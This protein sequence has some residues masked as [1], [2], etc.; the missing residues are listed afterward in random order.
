MYSRD[1]FNDSVAHI[2]VPKLTFEYGIVMDWLSKPPVPED[3]KNK[4]KEQLPEFTQ[5][6]KE[7]GEPLLKMT[8]C[9][10]G[11]KFNRHELT[12]ACVLNPDVC[13]MSQPLIINAASYIE[14]KDNTGFVYDVYLQL[15]RLYIEEHFHDLL[16][17]S[18]LANSFGLT[19]GFLF[20]CSVTHAVFQ[21]TGRVAELNQ[22]TAG[23]A[24]NSE[25]KKAWEVVKQDDGYKLFIQELK[26]HR[27]ASAILF[28]EER[29]K[30]YVPHIF[31]E[32]A[33]DLDE[34]SGA[35]VPHSLITRFRNELMPE[36]AEYWKN[37][38]T[39]LVQATVAF[40]KKGFPQQELSVA[41]ALDPNTRPMSFP[42]LTNARR[43]FHLNDGLEKR[44]RH[45]FCS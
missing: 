4:L 13:S 6:W 8:V 20:A 43:Q 16:Q 14:N 23:T 1:F 32:Y 9:L 31:L 38:G 37:K 10:I 15:V 36:L 39:E 41:L 34:S 26:E 17:S 11:K 21:S 35:L 2:S 3:L 5:S 44:S 27:G 33:K 25:A 45:F 42:L 30:P 28:K 22:L 24:A 29:S 12:A 7:K 40:F 19:P 18:N